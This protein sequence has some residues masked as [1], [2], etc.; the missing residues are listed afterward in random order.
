MIKFDDNRFSAPE[1]YSPKK[2]LLAA[3][4]ILVTG[5]AID[6]GS[7]AARA[8]ASHGATVVLLDHDVPA[9][10]AIYDDI[11]RMNAPEPAIYPMSLMGATPTHY[12]ELADRVDSE[13]GRLDGLLHAGTEL[14]TPSPI[15]HYDVMQW[16]KVIQVNLHAPFLLTRACLPLL[17]RAEDASVVFTSA[18]VGRRGRAYWGAYGVSK[19]AIEGLVQILADE[20]ET[21]SHVRVNGVDPGAVRTH[22][23]SAA[24]PAENPMILLKPEEVMPIY[25]FL[26]G[27]DSRSLNGVVVTS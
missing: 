9:L 21:E 8:F 19:F 2:D 13:F 15:E 4:V 16:A 7:A 14:G 18:D 5:A 23:R 11:S 17:K 10:E 3:H 24:Y 1:S 12:E 20:L 22:L 26:M 6:L 25:L 27:K